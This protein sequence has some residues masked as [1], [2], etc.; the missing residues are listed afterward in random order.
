MLSLRL[1][2][3]ALGCA[4][5]I[6]LSSARS[7]P[8][9]LVTGVDLQPIAAQVARLQDALEHLGAPLSAADKQALAAAA[10]EKDP[11]RG[12]AKIQQV[13]D[14]RCL[15]GVTINPEMRVKIARGPAVA[16][17]DEQ[18]WR[19]FLVK[20]EN[21]AGTTSPLKAES[22]NAQRL[23]GSPAIDVPARWLDLAMFDA[24]PLLPALSG[25]KV[26]Y[27][28]IQLYSRDPG[29]REATIAFNVG[30]GTQDL[31]FRNE[32]AVLF[33]AKPA[34]AVKLRVRDENGAPTVA[35]F[36]I[37]DRQGRVYPSPAKR[38]AP[39]FAFHHQVYRADGDVLKLPDGDY[40]IDSRAAPNRSPKRFHSR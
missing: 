20:V 27:R 40:R 5:S 18:G 30:Q 21:D 13:L 12:L 4:V 39:D 28:I 35:C 22:P 16:E 33:S 9:P 37:R 32:V 3:L 6:L 11:A 7:N 15:F 14:A 1:P 26:E 31:G 10:A 2:T 17:L 25:L 38:L 8:L 36:V 29:Q 34:R 19:V 23:F 24:Q